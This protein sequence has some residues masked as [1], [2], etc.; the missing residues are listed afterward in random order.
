V[1][2][3]PEEPVARMAVDQAEMAAQTQV[4]EEEAEVR[5]T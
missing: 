1:P 4:V 2:R 3:L 5:L